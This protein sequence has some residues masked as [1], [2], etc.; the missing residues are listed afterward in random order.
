MGANLPSG[1]VYVFLEEA[2]GPL[3][4]FLYGWAALFVVIS[5]GIAAVAVGFA[6]YLSYFIPGLGAAS[7]AGI[8]GQ[9]LV[10]AA[11]IVVLGAINYV[12]VRSGNLVSVVTTAAKV[13]AL[14]ALPIMA[15]IAWRV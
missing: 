15:M 10:A 14:A 13:A 5:G 9:K 11:V 3:T 12:G 1:G 6:V 7:V 8:D 2:Y 4:A